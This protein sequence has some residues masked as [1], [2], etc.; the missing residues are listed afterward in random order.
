[1]VIEEDKTLLVDSVLNVKAISPVSDSPR[2][3]DRGVTFHGLV[4]KI[5]QTFMKK[6]PCPNFIWKTFKPLNN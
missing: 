6:N 3:L 1:M 2:H 4:S 5:Y